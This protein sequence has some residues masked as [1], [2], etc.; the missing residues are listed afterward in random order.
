MLVLSL[1]EVSWLG[2]LPGELP[3]LSW[4]FQESG[5]AVGRIKSKAHHVLASNLNTMKLQISVT[6][7]RRF[8]LGRSS[9][10]CFGPLS[11]LARLIS[12][13]DSSSIGLLFLPVVQNAE[14]AGGS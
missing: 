2:P 6:L 12:W 5:K 7:L 14:L 9:I 10:L 3:E 8:F 4:A 11:S 13:S 1:E